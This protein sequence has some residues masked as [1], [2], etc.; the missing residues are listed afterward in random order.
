MQA[1]VQ[2][3]W[4]TLIVRTETEE[5]LEFVRTG[6]GG[7]LVL[8]FVAEVG[9]DPDDYGFSDANLASDRQLRRALECFMR[10]L[11]GEDSP[12]PTV[13][14]AVR[15][16]NVEWKPVWEACKRLLPTL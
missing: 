9:G 1:V 8:D 6:D 16:G 5:V 14:L 3:R 12:N 7:E 4:L 13:A 11:A 15:S 2:R 10:D